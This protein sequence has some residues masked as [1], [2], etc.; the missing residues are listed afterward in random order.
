MRREVRK[1]KTLTGGGRLM[2]RMT[3]PA[4]IKEMSRKM[5]IALNQIGMR[6]QYVSEM[7]SE[8]TSILSAM[9][10]KNDPNLLAC[11]FQF[12]AIR[13]SNC[14]SNNSKVNSC[15]LRIHI[16]SSWHN[17][18]QIRYAGDNEQSNCQLIVALNDDVANVWSENT[19][20][21]AQQIRN[22]QNV[23]AFDNLLHHFDL[24][25]HFCLFVAQLLHQDFFALLQ[26]HLLSRDRFG[27]ELFTF[28]HFQI[29]F[30]S[31]DI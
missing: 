13:P 12:R 14:E 21:H 6:P 22:G 19:T 3:N 18:Y 1:I 17:I 2:Y 11:D 9:G 16:R 28:G 5:T 10:S 15:A 23:F 8:P 26:F 7:T 30:L 4:V 25:L 24:F 20:S 31:M 29:D 27:D